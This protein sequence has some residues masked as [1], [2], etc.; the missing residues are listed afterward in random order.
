MHAAPAFSG[1][2]DIVRRVVHLRLHAGTRFEAADRFGLWR[3]ERSEVIAHGG[4]G[5]LESE[6][7]QFLM[8][9]DGR[10]IR[11]ARQKRCDPVLKRI[12]HAF[13]LSFAAWQR[14]GSGLLV[15]INNAIDAFT[16]D[17][18]RLRYTAV[19]GFAVPHPDDLIAHG[20]VHR[21]HTP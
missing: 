15:F 11:I 21:L 16:A 19:R 1:E 9:P 8:Q 5:S 7:G 2:V 10:D 18:E 6:R 3:P 14:A 12:E 20:F 13:R 4:V 17:A